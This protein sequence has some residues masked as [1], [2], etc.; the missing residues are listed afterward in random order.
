[1][2]DRIYLV[3]DKND[4]KS[5]SLVRAATAA[6]AERFVSR[7]HFVATVPTPEQ[8]LEVGA[9]GIKVEDAGRE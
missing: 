5:R 8:L 3:T 9:A 1:M 7:K 4:P 6:Q 2:S